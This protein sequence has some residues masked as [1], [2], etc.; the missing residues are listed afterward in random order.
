M[1]RGAALGP[2]LR[3]RERSGWEVE[4]RE[5]YPPKELSAARPPAQTAGDHEMNHEIQIVLEREHDSLAKAIERAYTFA[6]DLYE[7]RLDR[8]KHKGAENPR[9]L[10]ALTDHPWCQRLEI[11]ENVGHLGHVRRAMRNEE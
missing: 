6:F 10:Y 3:E 4:C 7:R 1:N 8:S 9:V 11:G 2:G 5:R